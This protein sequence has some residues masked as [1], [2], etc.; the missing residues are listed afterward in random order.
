MDW[1][2]FNEHNKN[3]QKGISQKQK[4]EIEIEI[5]YNNQKYVR[6]IYNKLIDN[7]YFLDISK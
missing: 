5:S 7:V 1:I 3:N 6:F 4:I 2:G